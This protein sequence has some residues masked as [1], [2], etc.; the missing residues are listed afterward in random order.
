MR[1]ITPGRTVGYTC[2]GKDDHC[3]EPCH[4]RIDS[5][6]HGWMDAYH[7][8][9]RQGWKAYRDGT[10]EWKHACPA[11]Y[12]DWCR[13]AGVE[14][15]ESSDTTTYDEVKA[16]I[17]ENFGEDHSIEPDW[18][19]AKEE[20]RL[21]EQRILEERRRK[22]RTA[23]RKRRVRVGVSRSSVVLYRNPFWDDHS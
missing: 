5:F 2:D 14:P 7:A 3:G 21:A 15:Y 10:G 19:V 13:R 6:E 9:Q 18:W 16:A 8:V 22:A 12:V 23:K 1:Q 11:C 17:A 4:E 20:Q